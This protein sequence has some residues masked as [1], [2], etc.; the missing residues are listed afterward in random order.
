MTMGSTHVRTSIILYGVMLGTGLLLAVASEE[1][2]TDKAVAA[3]KESK[4]ISRRVKEGQRTATELGY[5]IGPTPW[6]YMLEHETDE[7]GR[8]PG[9]TPPPESSF[10]TQA[11]GLTS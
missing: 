5:H 6:G 4:R 11:Y 8:K 1:K 7:R 10:Q 9:I 2:W 3:Q